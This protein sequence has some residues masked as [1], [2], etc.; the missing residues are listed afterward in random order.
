M[1]S[2][3][4]CSPSKWHTVSTRCSS[5]RGPAMVPS[6]VTCPTRMVAMLCFLAVCIRVLV[7][8]FT[9]FIPPMF[10]SISVLLTVCTESTISSCG[11]VCSMCPRILP[12]S[13]SA[14]RYRWSVR[15]L[16]RW[17]LRCTCATDSSAVM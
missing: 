7:T 9:W 17:A 13:V 15:A 16:M 14:V 1:R 8:S 5:V 11:L 4:C 10:P 6:L 12:R 3:L 2:R